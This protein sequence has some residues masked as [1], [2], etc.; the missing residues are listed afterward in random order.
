MKTLRWMFGI[1]SWDCAVQCAPPAL[2][3]D[4]IYLGLII[5]ATDKYLLVWNAGPWRETIINVH[6]LVRDHILT[7]PPSHARASPVPPVLRRPV[8]ALFLYL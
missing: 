3:V 6:N 8:T 7:H 4:N 2:A 5:Y 1:S